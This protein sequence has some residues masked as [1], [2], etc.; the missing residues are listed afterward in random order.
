MMD[1]V[2]AVGEW[3]ESETK[4]FWQITPNT[5][6]WAGPLAHCSTGR[7]RQA[8]SLEKSNLAKS[9]RRGSDVVA[10]TWMNASLWKT[11]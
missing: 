2:E 8:P 9:R 10:G 5:F 4:A 7:M 11:K 6:I 3:L 1:M